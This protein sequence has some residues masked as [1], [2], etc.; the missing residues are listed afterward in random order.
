[1]NF[2]LSRFN[3]GGEP[4]R[5]MTVKAIQGITERETSMVPSCTK[6]R[7]F[8]MNMATPESLGSQEKG[9]VG[10]GGYGEMALEGVF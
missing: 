10:L 9:R 7:I 4:D 8:L 3:E 1:M 5:M 6:L 2:M